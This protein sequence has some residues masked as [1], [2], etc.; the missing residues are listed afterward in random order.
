MKPGPYR[1]AVRRLG[2]AGEL[3]NEPLERSIEHKAVELEMRHL[4]RCVPTD[5]LKDVEIV[6]FLTDILGRVPP[7][8]LV[9]RLLEAQRGARLSEQDFIALERKQN[10]RCALCGVVL[11]RRVR[12][13]VDH[14]VAV[15]LRG[16]SDISN[17]QILCQKCNSGKGSSL[18]WVMAAPFFYVCIGVVSNKMRY[19]V[20]AR[21]ESACTWPG[22]NETASTSALEAVER[23]PV[24]KGGRLVFDNLR[25]LCESHESEVRERWL[26]EARLRL[27]SMRAGFP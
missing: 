17:Y 19:A 1:I 5:Q 15:A 2:A 12:P 3:L 11:A 22:C 25:T 16:M 27:R 14:I 6:R 10:G 20:L 21:D 9:D 23:V 8:A 18:H 4:F 7:Q 26:S 24:S 13:Q